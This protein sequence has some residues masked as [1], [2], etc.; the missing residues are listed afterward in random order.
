MELKHYFGL[1][2]FMYRQKQVSQPVYYDP[3]Y[4][5]NGHMALMGS[6][7]TGKSYQSM[8]FLSSAA[9]AGLHVDIFDVHDELHTTSRAVSCKYSQ[10]TG[11]GYN[12]LVLDT[13]PHT[14]GVDRQCNYLVKLIKSVSPALGS[15]Q[16]AAL[17]YLLTD[18]YAASGI[19]QRTPST[20]VR[21]EMSEDERQRMIDQRDYQSLRNYYPTLEDLKSY[22]K[23][24]VL[25]ITIGGDSK[26]ISAFDRLR[27][28]KNKL[29][30]LLNKSK[31]SP[32]I[33]PE[34]IDKQ[35]SKI[36]NQK[37]VAIEMY[38]AFVAAMETGK[39]VDD[40]FKYDSVDV[41]L[42]VIQ[43]LDILNSAG[44]FRSNR[45]P[46]GD[47]RVCVHQMISLDNDQ[48]ILFAKLRMRELFD[49]W[50][51][52][53][54]TE[55]G[56]EIRQVIFLDEAHK[57]FT[58]DADDIINVLAKEGRKFGIALWCASQQPTEFPESFLTNCGT[59]VILGIHPAY[60]K[61][62]IPMFRITEEQL[63]FIKPKEVIAVR[64]Q[65]DGLA[66]PQFMHIIVPNPK[67]SAG[68]AAAS[69]A[70]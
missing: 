51:K 25:A 1:A 67:T 46:F 28:E 61:R 50:K 31:K 5:T 3:S 34:E 39:E 44:I 37:A 21:L 38:S 20:W 48:Q 70:F 62:A 66:D 24:K 16:E 4:L 49:K 33:T 30:M 36:E 22:A 55:S 27:G 65:K 2:E 45:P 17:R 29:S 54:P 58:E 8:R 42:S 12:P 57:Y 32:G 35:K 63:K 23:R 64:L 41:L 18:V 11:F 6:S 15:K 26:A 10:A 60:W 40:V 47:A 13:D 69:T 19:F 14:G 53:G 59:T 68:Q 56:T 7:G 43:R 9:N 52:L